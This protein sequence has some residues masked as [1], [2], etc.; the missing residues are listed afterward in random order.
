MPKYCRVTQDNFLWKKGAIL[1][2]QGKG[3]Y[4]GIEDIWDRIHNNEHISATVIEHPENVQFFERIYPDT[5]VGK[6]FR[7]KDQ[8]IEVCNTAFK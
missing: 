3:Q 4:V 6:Y 2:D 8:F 7:T 5:V 1:T